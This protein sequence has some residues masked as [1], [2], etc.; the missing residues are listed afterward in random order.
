MTSVRQH[1]AGEGP[2]LVLR[3]VVKD[4]GGFRALHGVDF[5][6]ARGEVHALLGENGAGK[7]TL[8]NVL[9]G[10]VPADS[11][12]VEICGERVTLHSP[13]DAF[14]RGVGIVHQHFRLI[15]KLTVAES[16]HLGWEATPLLVSD[17]ALRRRT[18]ALAE[19]FGIDVDPSAR[20]WQLST[21]ERQRVAILRA[22]A[23]GAEILILDEP[24]ATLAPDET[25]ELLAAIDRIRTAGHTVVFISHKLNEVLEIADRI[26]VLRG[27]RCVAAG[28]AKAD[29]DM[30]AL[31]RLMVGHGVEAV[32]RR[33]RTTP[34][35]TP[36][37]ELRGVCADDD[38]G[39]RSLH[40]V[41]LAVG[42]GEIVGVAGVSGNGQRELAEAIARLRAV[43]AGSI[44]VD[45]H[46]VT[47]AAPVD[48]IRAGVGYIPEDLGIGLALSLPV[49][50]N[51]AMKASHEQPLRRGVWLR[52][53]GVR[54]FAADLLA[55]AA[56][57]AAPAR[58]ATTLSGGQAQRLIAHRELR[59]ARRALVA[60]HPTRGLDVAAAGRVQEL[61]L[62]AR[63]AGTAVLLVSEDLDEVLA[64]S[65][66]V[67]VLYEGRV[68][69]TFDHAAASRDQVGALMGGA[70]AQAVPA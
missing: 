35:G 27:G 59:A 51:A 9:G 70:V 18:A 12:E 60:V 2:A 53:G 68:M 49:E 4:F 37:L 13:R 6:A 17:A 11:G 15:D 67:V 40:S 5:E 42:A 52:R 55:G 65:D 38:F 33:D 58:D 62:D 10:I 63:A 26:T 43:T 64:L 8:M 44:E 28:L 3:Q 54:A 34:S 41:D 47:D 30:D 29:C 7:T 25:A 1:A 46:D 56:L 24:T 20:I 39:R 50:V 23:R 57:G 32:R 21:G 14:D 66:R 45:G 19:Q 69:G 31:A 48:A 16:V 22:L 36:V 61:L